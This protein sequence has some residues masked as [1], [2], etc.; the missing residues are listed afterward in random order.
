M[1][2]WQKE[3]EA[4]VKWLQKKLADS[5][6]N[7]FVFGNSGGKDSAL[8]GILCKAACDYTLGV[9]MP[10]ESKVNYQQDRKDALKIAEQFAI[11]TKT[12]DLT[13]VKKAFV[14]AIGGA[15]NYAQN[16][17]ANINPRLRMTVVYTLAQQRGCLVAGTG[18]LSEY[19]MGYFTKHGDGACDINPIGDLTATEVFAFLRFLNA[20]S[21]I[22]TKAP[23][24]GLWEGQT[25][26]TEMGITYSELDGYLLYG[27]A[28]PE[29]VKLIASVNAKTAHKRSLPLRYPS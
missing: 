10:C 4:R 18:N 21:S 3:K 2:D 16:A 5:G 22:I 17:L 26:E 9:I 25:D 11:E 1:R 14:S 7:G 24:A 27:K 8:V 29:S 12:V 23:S 13:A 19:T 15:N 28:S 6:A 20:P